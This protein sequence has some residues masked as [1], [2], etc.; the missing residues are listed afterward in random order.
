MHVSSRF[1]FFSI[2][3]MVMLGTFMAEP[4]AFAVETLTP[5]L[6][7][8]TP[9]PSVKQRLLYEKLHEST[10][11]PELAH[12]F[13]PPTKDLPPLLDADDYAE[14]DN[15]T[16]E[17]ADKPEGETLNIDSDKL[18]YDEIIKGYIITGNVH[19][20]VPEQG[21]TID[22]DK[23]TYLPEE[24]ILVAEGNLHMVKDGQ[25]TDAAYAR[26]RL[27]AN[28][29]LITDPTTSLEF[30]RLRARQ[31]L[32]RPD[33][34]HL[35]DGVMMI[36]PRDAIQSVRLG[37][38]VRYVGGDKKDGVVI[39]SGFT[40]YS[41]NSRQVQR[42]IDA[43]NLK[44]NPTEQ[45]QQF[46]QR[47]RKNGVNDALVVLNPDQKEE[48]PDSEFVRL[49]VKDVNVTQYPDDYYMIDL[50]A[51]RVRYKDTSILPLP[52]LD[53][54]F[55]KKHSRL[56]YLG[57]EFG[58]N[59]DLG[60]LFYNPGF[61][62]KVGPGV[63]KLSPMISYGE[64]V[65]RNETNIDIKEPGF[66][67][68]V[69]SSYR[70]DRLKL[71]AG[72][73]FEN[74]Y[75]VLSGELRL[76][77]GKTRLVASQNAFIGA[78]IFTQERPSWS[79]QAIDNRIFLSGKLFA[80]AAGH[81]AGVYKD[82]F[83]PFNSPDP[84]IDPIDPTKAPT[85][86]RIQQQLQLFNT[87]PLFKFGNFLELGF[88]AQASNAAYTS[89]DVLSV[90]RAGPSANLFLGDFFISQASYSLAAISGQSPF[91]F[92]SF[93]LG[94]HS[95]ALNNAIRLGPHV[96]IGLRQDFNLDRDNARDAAIV[97]N[98]V[99]ASVGTRNV[100]FMIGYDTIFRLTRFGISYYPNTAQAEVEFDDAYLMSSI[101]PLNPSQ[102]AA[103]KKWKKGEDRSKQK[104]T[105]A[106][107][108]DMAPATM[109]TPGLI[110]L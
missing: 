73:N 18:V 11:D 47:L 91:V 60:G 86:G 37:R 98:T 54:G 19:M 32:V 45:A 90:F 78:N 28:S 108:L 88:N 20:M 33:I 36:V 71:S 59:R 94:R 99:Y 43:D 27:D 1:L 102:L 100:K 40:P 51:P 109:V 69:M 79:A 65:N 67:Y 75:N 61:D 17:K 87:R 62:Y 4:L 83:F 85:E 107:N 49:V 95:V 35:Q 24:D 96:S 26:I 70:A 25:A 12:G 53:I 50:K 76:F 7:L 103:F 77:D 104:K 34:T 74:D 21:V 9:D 68:G 5:L 56:D 22:A 41:I 93:F 106:I 110:G 39:Q 63:L 57:P 84:F 13:T 8:A 58:F 97:G 89:G 31:G 6:P 44:E 46:V 38:G 81:S 105:D 3:G 82:D 2:L 15:E 16:V 10:P 72:R 23:V 42:F 48:R 55:D 52:N 29:A 92:D 101:N 66:G 80:L 30:I 64:T 14:S